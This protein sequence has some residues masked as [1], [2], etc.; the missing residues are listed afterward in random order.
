MVLIILLTKDFGMFEYSQLHSYQTTAIEHQIHHRDSMLWLDMGLGK[1]V[2]TLSTIAHRIKTGE[3]SKVLIFGPLR[4]IHSVW[5]T[6]AKKWSHLKH[7]KFQ[8]IYG[9]DKQREM[10]M[11]NPHVDIYLINYENMSWLA[12]ILDHYFISQNK[13]L[14]YEMVVY[15]EV[16]KVKKSNTV[17]MSGGW[18]DEEKTIAKIGWRKILDHFNFRTGLTGTP[19]PNGYGDLH[20]QFL[21]VD[22][23]KRLL[24]FVTHF[25]EKYLNRN[26]NGFGYSVTSEGVKSIRASI[27]DITI[28]MSASDH[29]KMPDS[30]INDVYVDLPVKV[31]DLYKELENEFFVELDND[32]DIEVFNKASLSNKC[33]QFCNGS[34]YKNPNEPEWH[35]LHNAKIKALESILE[36]ANGNPVL[37]AYTFKSDAERILKTFKRFLPVNITTVKP[38]NLSRVLGDIKNN[39]HQVILGHPASMGHGIDG[40]QKVC[41]IG[42]WFGLNWNLEYYQQF[43][44]R[45]NRQGQT[46]TTITHRILCQGTIDMV[47]RDTIEDKNTNQNNLKKSIQRY[48]D[49]QRFDFW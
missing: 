6:E 46:K 14:P 47:V 48:R 31:M 34:P 30:I 17:R 11:F 7:L 33:L 12:G 1:T 9:T 3:V 20:G 41:H 13:K 26:Y 28:H 42:V 5:T 49:K 24:K 45:Y 40:L 35:L 2:I 43:I 23:G 29:L 25:R 16:T 18:V 15:D 37:V 39:R 36:E 38:K 4:V 22:G 21:A 32:V 8:V 27:Q 44:A 19:S 10:R